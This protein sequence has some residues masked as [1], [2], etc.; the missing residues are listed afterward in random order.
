MAG[1][2]KDEQAAAK[3][4]AAEVRKQATRAR[5]QDKRAADLADVLAAIRGGE[6]YETLWERVR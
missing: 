6:G 5:G 4:R 1:L 3:E 2:S